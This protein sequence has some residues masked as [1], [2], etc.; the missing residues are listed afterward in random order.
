[1][2]FAVLMIGVI[3]LLF[4]SC[5]EDDTEGTGDPAGRG[6]DNNPLTKHPIKHRTVD[7]DKNI[8]EMRSAKTS[9]QKADTIRRMARI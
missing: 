3:C 6:V 9:A 4:C 7:F 1:M 8:T 2:K 5:G